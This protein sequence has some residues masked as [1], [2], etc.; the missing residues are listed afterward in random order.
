MYV[1]CFLELQTLQRFYELATWFWC[2]RIAQTICRMFHAEYCFFSWNRT[3]LCLFIHIRFCPL[4]CNLFIFIASSSTGDLPLSP[5]V[6]S[7]ASAIPISSPVIKSVDSR[8]K[9]DRDRSNSQSKNR[10]PGLPAKRK[11][12]VLSA[13]S[14]GSVRR[15]PRFV[16]TVSSPLFPV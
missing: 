16:V 10:K 15:S 9:N 3:I 14:P 2:L 12:S 8:S 5:T 13:A 11:A 4:L 1:A 7:D 6:C